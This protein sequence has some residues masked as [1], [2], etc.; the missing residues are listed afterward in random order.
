[1]KEEHTEAYRLRTGLANYVLELLSDVADLSVMT[2]SLFAAGWMAAANLI[3]SL[4]EE[5]RDQA[6]KALDDS[7]AG[8]RDQLAMM[9]AQVD[10]AKHEGDL[11]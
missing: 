3:S 7:I 4:P 8:N 5:Q 2:D 6:M 11:Q 1:M 10:A 9:I